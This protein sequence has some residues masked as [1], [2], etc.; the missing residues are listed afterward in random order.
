[1]G[2]KRKGW[3]QGGVEGATQPHRGLTDPTRSSR[4]KGPPEPSRLRREAQ[5]TLGGGSRRCHL[6]QTDPGPEGSWGTTAR[7]LFFT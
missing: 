3:A 4:A 2:G 5:V 6:G 1:M 7:T